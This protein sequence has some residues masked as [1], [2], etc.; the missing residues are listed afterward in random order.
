MPTA[1]VKGQGL[2]KPIKP[3]KGQDIRNL[4]ESSLRVPLWCDPGVGYS[5]SSPSPHIAS[6]VLR[7]VTGMAARDETA[8]RRP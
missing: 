3:V 5:Y 4:D 1:Y 2:P 8:G 6:I 7:Q